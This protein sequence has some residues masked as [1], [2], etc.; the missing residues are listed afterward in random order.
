MND[1]RELAA[2]LYNLWE[3][4][5]VTLPNVAAVYAQGSRDVNNTTWRAEEAFVD[6]I[7]GFELV[8]GTVTEVNGRSVED[9]AKSDGGEAGMVNYT[10]TSPVFAE[11]SGLR[12]ILQRVLC[13]TS[14]RLIAT[15]E[16]LVRIEQDYAATDSE[17]AAEVE[18]Q[19]QELLADKTFNVP[20]PPESIPKA[21]A[22]GDAPD[23]SPVPANPFDGQEPL[24]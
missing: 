1:S 16:A 2:E 23:L 5:A 14:G 10:I 17:A 20:K 21:K 13:E 4:G 18:R 8:T 15:G 11:W 12:D 19:R 7:E 3:V 6:S 24:R 9:A 22:P